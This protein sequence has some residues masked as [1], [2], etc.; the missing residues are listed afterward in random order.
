MAMSLD[1]KC[2]VSETDFLEEYSADD[3]PKPSVTVDTVIFTIAHVHDDNHRKLP[4]MELQVL[5]IKRGEHPYKGQ[6][7]LPGGFVRPHET[8]GDAARRELFEETGIAGG[9]L[10]Q[11][12]TFSEPKRDP[13]AWIITCAHLALLDSHNLALRAGSDA[14]EASWFTI[15]L[16]GQND[17]SNL[18]LTSE[19]TTISALVKAGPRY[20]PPNNVESDHLAFDHASIIVYALNRLRGKLDYSDLAYSL[21]P[22]KFTL[23][24]LQQVHETILDEPL[25]K[26]AFRRKIADKVHPTGEYTS[27]LGHRPSQLFTHKECR[28]TQ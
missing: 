22:K 18:I 3:Y 17:Y 5:L 26:A 11:L 6:W 9:H 23:T 2:T 13:R 25:L 20:D 4:K 16:D 24:E 7:A 19:N 12:Y 8:V 28:D 15:T 21:L 1:P 27:K 10:E 14:E